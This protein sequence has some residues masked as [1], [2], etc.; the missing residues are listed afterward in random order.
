MHRLIT[1]FTFKIVLNKILQKAASHLV[2][3]FFLWFSDKSRD[4]NGS[5]KFVTSMPYDY[6]TA[7]RFQTSTILDVPLDLSK[8]LFVNTVQSMQPPFLLAV[9]VVLTL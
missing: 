1:Y 6:H 5:S 4:C 3:G 2:S 7:S 9:F 8:N